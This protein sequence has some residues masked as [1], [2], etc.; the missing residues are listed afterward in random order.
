[1]TFVDIFSCKKSDW[2][3]DDDWAAWRG[4]WGL[5]SNTCIIETTIFDTVE[6]T[7]TFK[8]VRT[9]KN[10]NQKGKRQF[11]LVKMNELILEIE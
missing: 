1:M 7:P 11:L 3:W 4:R 5:W 9:Q 6:F 10:G 2:D 8:S